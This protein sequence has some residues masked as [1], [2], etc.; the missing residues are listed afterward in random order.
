MIWIRS[1]IK[2]K[3]LAPLVL[4]FMLFF[5]VQGQNI[6][7]ERADK[8][9]VTGKVIYYCEGKSLTLSAKT[10]NPVSG[11]ISYLWT[12]L[13]DPYLFTKNNK[14]V[15]PD[16]G[17]YE[18][19]IVAAGVE[20]RDTFY[21]KYYPSTP[22]EIIKNPLPLKC[23]GVP[24]TLRASKN[25]TLTNYKWY[26]VM[27]TTALSRNDS[28]MDARKGTIYIARAT[29]A[30]KCI[31]SDTVEVVQSPFVP[32]V[33]LGSKDTVV[34]EGAI[35]SL[36]NLY[37]TSGDYAWSTGETAA[38]IKIRK[39]SK[40]WVRV[41]NSFRCYA[42]DTINV[43][44]VPAP[45]ILPAS[46]FYSC[47]N[48]GVKIGVE[49]TSNG[50]LYNYEWSP[51]VSIK[52]AG[53]KNPTVKPLS[54]TRY[55]VRVFTK[56]GCQDTA[57]VVVIPNPE[58]TAKV[59]FTDTTIC[60]G[61]TIELVGSGSGGIPD[62][63]SPDPYQYHWIAS[64][65]LVSVTKTKASVQ[66]TNNTSYL[67]TITDAKSCSDTASVSVKTSQFTVKVDSPKTDFCFG[68]SIQLFA[69]PEG[70]IGPYRYIWSIGSP[71]LS[72]KTAKDPFFKPGYPGKAEFKVSVTDDIGC[73]GMKDVSFNIYPP[74]KIESFKDSI[75][76]CLHDTAT[77]LLKASG[78]SG[79]GYKFSASSP[80]LNLEEKDNAMLLIIGKKEWTG[81][82]QVFVKVKDD[83]GCSS[84]SSSTEVSVL[85]SFPVLFDK[86]SIVL[87]EGDTVELFDQNLFNKG[88]K[89]NWLSE[90]N[91]LVS[92]DSVYHAFKGGNFRLTVFNQQKLCPTSDNIK[93]SLLPTSKGL[94]VLTKEFYC[95]N[96]GIIIKAKDY[97]NTSYD[98]K[99]EKSDISL[100]SKSEKNYFT[101][102]QTVNK[103]NHV[104]IKL[105]IRNKCSNKDT[106]VNVIIAPSPVIKIEYTPETIYKDSTVSFINLSAKGTELSWNFNQSDILIAGDTVQ[107]KFS[108][109]GKAQVRIRA[110]NEY[111]CYAEDSLLLDIKG[112][113]LVKELFIPN[114]FSPL[115]KNPDNSTFKVFGKNIDPYN[116]S[117]KVF[118]K[119]G[120]LLYS[121]DD[122][123][124]AT[125]KGWTASGVENSAT[126]MGVYTYIVKGNF[127]DG[128]SF[129]RSGAVTLIK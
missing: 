58:L 49:L 82:H 34:C 78:G 117:L 91:V 48:T 27:D 87:C 66:P 29:D 22:F 69:V 99:V 116:F 31:V 4:V 50:D 109:L 84:A 92:T 15:V 40:V 36:K 7:V 35:V 30:N 46:N 126:P 16:T 5:H 19:K 77:I 71:V 102:Y 67:F 55:R 11:T 13:N 74:P 73:S 100:E 17:A 37:T 8:V 45:D 123:S 121:T 85:P 43:L 112:I 89:F 18:I 81:H 63:S 12:Y 118:N 33:E 38:N 90:N 44:V 25:S 60:L 52:N 88:L 124:E 120:D 95:V 76:L 24:L 119:W 129:L 6:C 110:G 114:V 103:I 2:A 51:N 86:E 101:L 54:T 42:T 9:P 96:E 98:W 122:L 62:I 28:L 10:C 70:G 53:T 108:E 3:K 41:T 26:T 93:L 68:D 128:E 75:T 115:S 106:I 23:E 104:D 14:F 111:Q 21:L 59:L 47:H 61:R 83:R 97:P 64:P 56:S 65:E 39:S 127:A 1:M 80:S 79:L 57:S 113:V 107:Y 20:S 105:T 72:D 125:S 32:K 94:E